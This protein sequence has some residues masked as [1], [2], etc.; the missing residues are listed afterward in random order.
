M[1]L[2]PVRQQRRAATNG[3][4]DH[5]EL[6]RKTE[7][8]SAYAFIAQSDSSGKWL[9]GREFKFDYLLIEFWASWCGPCRE[10]NPQTVRLYREYHPRG[11]EIL[12]IS[13]DKNRTNWVR[14]I[15][16]DSLIWP[17]ISDLKEF[18][19]EIAKCYSVTGIPF[20]LLIN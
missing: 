20:N 9:S 12:G 5:M 7:P 17:L 10:D 13:L 19:N 4:A 6:L 15:Q 2:I 14:A 1:I 11:F 16:N 8:G 18:D 3:V